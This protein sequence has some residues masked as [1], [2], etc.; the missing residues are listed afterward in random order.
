MKGFLAPPPP[1]ALAS[2]CSV[3]E[4]FRLMS[5]A[6]VAGTALSAA[7]TLDAL[8]SA[9]SLMVCTLHMAWATP[10]SRSCKPALSRS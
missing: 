1:V 10:H 5:F 2:F 3:V 8:T 6:T 4:L 9:L 7:G